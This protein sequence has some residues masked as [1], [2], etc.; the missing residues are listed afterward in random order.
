MFPQTWAQITVILAAVMPGF[1]YQVSRRRIAGPDPDEI[2]FGTRVLRAIMASA[3][4][5]GLYAVIFGRP[6]RGYL[7]NPDS[8]IE[9]VE[10][11]GWLFLLLVVV[12]PWLAARL[13]F[14]LS[15][16][17]RWLAITARLRDKLH[18]RRQWDPTP[19]AWDFAFSTREPGWVRVRTADGT[20][21]GGWFGENSFA[22][23]YPDPQELY[24]EAGYVMAPDGTFTEALSAPSGLFVRCH[25]AIVVDFIPLEADKE[26]EED[27]HVQQGTE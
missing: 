10:G 22:S 17:A 1:V 18:L 4:F 24:L 14:Y 7:R 20:W 12:I 3:V 13:A 25:V 15:T 26:C 9:D 2:E 16:S 27:D 23:S 21:V 19:S 6:L 11:L 5:A 8:V